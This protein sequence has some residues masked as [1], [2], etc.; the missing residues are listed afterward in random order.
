VGRAKA[1]L[2][3]TTGG[4]AGLEDKESACL[5]RL[6]GRQ[7]EECRNLGVSTGRGARG[8]SDRKKKERYHVGTP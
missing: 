7:E 6:R 4:L 1:K 8:Q 3:M 5:D 2:E